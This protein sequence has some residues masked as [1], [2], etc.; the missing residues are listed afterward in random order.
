[1][2]DWLGRMLIHAERPSPFTGVP[3]VV[4]VTLN[5]MF[6]SSAALIVVAFGASGSAVNSIAMPCSTIFCGP[7]GLVFCACEVTVRMISNKNEVSVR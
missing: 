4:S 7:A 2:T 3:V 6:T 5:F 1:M